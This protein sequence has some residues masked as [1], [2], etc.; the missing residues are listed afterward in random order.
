MRFFKFRGCTGTGIDLYYLTV[1]LWA[2]YPAKSVF[3]TSLVYQNSTG[4][5]IFEREKLRYSNVGAKGINW[6][7][8]NCKQHIQIGRSR[9]FL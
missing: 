6:T 4:T 5:G 7:K 8:L 3:V 2:G 1:G 9:F